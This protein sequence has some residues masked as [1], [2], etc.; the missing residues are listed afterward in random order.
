MADKHNLGQEG[1]DFDGKGTHFM[2]LYVAQIAEPR[3]AGRLDL[4]SVDKRVLDEAK[5]LGLPIKGAM[6]LHEGRWQ[7]IVVDYT[8]PVESEPTRYEREVAKEWFG[9]A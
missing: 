8:S 9:Q 3:V 6:T 7:E 1:A 4:D 2:N 5:R